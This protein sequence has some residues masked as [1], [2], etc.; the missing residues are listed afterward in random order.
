MILK[1][2]WMSRKIA[3]SV[4]TTNPHK[5][6]DETGYSA[7]AGRKPNRKM[8]ILKIQITYLLVLGYQI[9]IKLAEQNL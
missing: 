1:T 6:R 2:I 9:S 5:G 3:K 4:K 7:K 8:A